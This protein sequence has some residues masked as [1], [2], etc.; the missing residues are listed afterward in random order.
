MIKTS[1]K[2]LGDNPRDPK[3]KVIKIYHQHLGTGIVQF[4][5]PKLIID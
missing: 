3:K 4:K 5:K 2:T 1:L